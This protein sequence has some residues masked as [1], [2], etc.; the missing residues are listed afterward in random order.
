MK[1]LILLELAFLFLATTFSSNPPPGWYQ[2]TL[3]VSDQINDIFFL[4]SL[5]GW[6]VTPNGYIMNTQNGGDN[7]SIQS[8]FSGNLFTIQ[9]LNVET[10]Y[11][12]GRGNH[13]I[14][15]KTTNGGTNW[16][17][18]YN[19]SPVGVINDMRFVNKDTGWV[20]S[21]DAFDGGVFKTNDG[22]Q[23]WTRQI[24]LTTDNPNKIFFI[25]KDIGWVGNSFGKLYKTYNGGLNWNLQS[26]LGSIKDILFVNND[27][28]W[29]AES[30][31]NRVKFTTDGGDIW[32]TQTLPSKDSIVITSRPNQIS[33]ID[34]RVVYGV[35]GSA[36][37]G[38]GR[39]RGIVYKS[40]NS[41]NTW[42]Y[43]L[44]DTSINISGY[45]QIQFINDTVGWAASSGLIHTNDGGEVLVNVSNIN[46]E[47][48]KTF[49]LAQN[50]PNPFN[51][52]TNLEFGI[53]KLGFVSL[54]VYDIQGKKI[55]T[56]V[57]SKLNPGT[58]K[59]EF[60]GSNLNSGVYFYRFEVNNEKTNEVFSETKKMLLVK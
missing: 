38:N 22:G 14:I 34:G 7:W 25:N 3:P 37:F 59:Y 10:G 36:F 30:N 19:F 44:P 27:T 21:Q 57:K 18:I 13:G 4:D 35:G 24:N 9:F 11:V 15:Y 46:S 6:V 20:C 53:S 54:K 12:S 32:V 31:Q 2:Q 23:S 1:K 55:T 28:G 52:V 33:S 17:L 43:Q 29:I 42:F 50:Y 60:D 26:S 56:I 49:T 41:G 39:F 58:Y 48:S 45:L 8:D 51:P 5:N 47:F 40:T 16:N